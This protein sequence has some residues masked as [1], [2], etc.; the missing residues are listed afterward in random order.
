[1][2]SQAYHESQII[3]KRI[4]EFISCAFHS[5][6]GYDGNIDLGHRVEKDEG[7]YHLCSIKESKI[8][9]TMQCFYT[10]S[11]SDY[12]I[13]ANTFKNF[14][15]AK[16]NLFSLNNIVIDI[17]NHLDIFTSET[18]EIFLARLKEFINENIILCPNIVVFTGRG[19][20][21]WYCLEAISYRYIY[22]YQNVANELIK[23]IQELF[24]DEFPHEFEGL[25]V[26]KTASA[27]AAGYYRLPFTTNTKTK[28][29]VLMEIL[30]IDFYKLNTL[31][32]VIAEK[33]GD[34]LEITKKE[35]TSNKPCTF[36]S[37]YSYRRCLKVIDMLYNLQKNRSAKIDIKGISHENRQ[38]LCFSLATFLS[39]IYSKED[40]YKRLFAFNRNFQNP[41]SEKKINYLIEYTTRNVLLENGKSKNKWTNKNL[42]DYLELTQEE[43]ETYKIIENSGDFYFDKDKCK[44]NA[45]RNLEVKLRKNERISSVLG[46]F[47]TGKNIT[48]ISKILNISRP[49]INKILR[50]N[51]CKK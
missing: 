42:I 19:I 10:S 12:Y 40:A 49:T 31:L 20:Q 46:L 28:T 41:L 36:N 44:P 16:A 33:N 9:E 47:K 45:T 51:G 5:H 6:E 18:S 13:S 37:N 50:E 25:A 21:L 26:D 43:Q 14:N 48:Q 35:Q 23:H 8:K 11:K 2:L 30:H 38:R 1:M 34:T 4:L 27:N 29:K 39:L 24:L 22:T 32:N 15:R 17:D 3:D 7:I